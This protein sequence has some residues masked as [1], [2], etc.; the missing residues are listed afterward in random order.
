MTLGQKKIKFTVDIA[1]LI[2]Y[3]AG[4]AWDLQFQP[5]H[6]Y[7]KQGSLHYIALAKDFNLFINGI[8]IKN[9]D[10]PEWIELGNYWKSLSTEDAKNTWGGDF[11]LNGDGKKGDDGG[12]FSIEHEGMK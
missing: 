9:S 3:A 7:H 10:A 6:C 2:I 8:W 4:K 5:E 12:H 1:S 11:D